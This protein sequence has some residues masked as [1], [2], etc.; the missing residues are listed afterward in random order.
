MNMS[1]SSKQAG[2]VE[3]SKIKPYLRQSDVADIVKIDPSD[4]VQVKKAFNQAMI[5]TIERNGRDPKKL[6]KKPKK[7]VNILET[8]NARDS[9]QAADSSS[10]YRSPIKNSM[11]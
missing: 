6:D 7:K 2:T 1:S 9:G 10:A 11:K 3:R 4:P 8:F 5:N